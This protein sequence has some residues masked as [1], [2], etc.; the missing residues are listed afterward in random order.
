MFDAFNAGDHTRAKELQLKF[1]ALN[2]AVTSRWSVPG[3][4]A[5]LDLMGDYY[6]GPPRLP[7]RSLEDKDC[8][9]LRKIMQGAGM[10]K[11]TDPTQPP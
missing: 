9:A 7:L 4:K 2:A 5:A 10:L 6:G 8:D 3:L 11:T 1:I